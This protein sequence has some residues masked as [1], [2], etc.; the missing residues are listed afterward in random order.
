MYKSLHI[1]IKGHFTYSSLHYVN[2]LHFTIVNNRNNN[3]NVTMIFN[4][5]LVLSIYQ[6]WQ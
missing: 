3:N 6:S 2:I 1:I 4:I 5:Y